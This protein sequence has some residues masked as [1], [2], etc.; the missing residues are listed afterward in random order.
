MKHPFAATRLLSIL[1]MLATCVSCTPPTFDPVSSAVSQGNT[2]AGE[3]G[4]A[5]KE[6][7][8]IVVQ[9]PVA[10]IGVSQTRPE[11]NIESVESLILQN[12]I[13]QTSLSGLLRFALPSGIEPN[14]VTKATLT[15]TP[16]ETFQTKSPL[17]V[18][19][20]VTTSWNSMDCSWNLIHQ[21]PPQDLSTPSVMR[22]DGRLDL[23]VTPIVQAWLRGDY[24]N[25]GFL[26]NNSKLDSRGVFYAPARSDADTAPSLTIEYTPTQH[27]INRYDFVDI[28]SGNCLSFALRDAV[29]I[30]EEQL[31][32]T[33]KDVEAAFHRGGDETLLLYLESLWRNYVT[34]H[35]ESLGV[36]SLREL[37]SFDA[38]IDPETEY[39]IA[40]RVG[41]VPLP[42]GE[43]VYDFHFQ[44]QLPDGSWAE[45]IGV[46]P[47]GKVPGSNLTLDPA[48]YPWHQSEFIGVSKHDSFH[49]SRPLYYAVQKKEVA[50]TKHRP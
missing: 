9:E 47:S 20:A 14:Q 41:A 35:Q 1:L 22:A 24:N 32:I 26:L 37:P 3:G 8:S 33:Q 40:F 38:E 5:G 15:L 12:N 36:V 29:P 34:S 49:T 39:R 23:T 4:E 11:E 13:D 28:E 44:V 7:R 48:R 27:Q 17:I 30:L 43:V 42:D 2:D 6:T 46:A 19:S 50:F 18:A 31:G 45:K 25:M 16:L 21:I 10:C